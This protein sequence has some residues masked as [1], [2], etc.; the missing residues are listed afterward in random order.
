MI[1]ARG[2]STNCNKNPLK[3]DFEKEELVK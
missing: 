3:A 1:Y 2:T